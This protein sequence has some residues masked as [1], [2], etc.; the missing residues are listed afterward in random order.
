MREI[1]RRTFLGG[2]LAL[3]VA[4]CGD[5]DSDPRCA[6]S[7]AATPDIPYPFTLGVASGDPLPGGIMLWTRL[8]P[9]ATDPTSMPAADVTVM[10]ELARDQAFT[11]V[12]QCGTFIATAAL[13]HSVH[14]DVRELSA[15]TTY[16]YRF[17]VGAHTSETGRT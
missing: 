10:W 13:G 8:A 17:H 3:G 4:A 16:W 7:S 5:G 1:S 6:D 9:V 11:N 12:E 2:V 14:I 15:G